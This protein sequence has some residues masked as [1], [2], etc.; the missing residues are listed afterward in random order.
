M[1]VARLVIGYLE[2]TDED[3]EQ[4]KTKGIP[5]HAEARST[6]KQIQ[7]WSLHQRLETCRNM[8]KPPLGT[9]LYSLSLLG[10]AGGRRRWLGRLHPRG[11]GLTLGRWR[12]FL[13]EPWAFKAKKAFFGHAFRVEAKEQSLREA[14]NS[15]LPDFRVGKQHLCAESR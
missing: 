11:G 5:K 6:I 8:S 13:P 1:H 4:L 2:G 3:E 9:H 7:S 14:V 15:L 10:S 12:L